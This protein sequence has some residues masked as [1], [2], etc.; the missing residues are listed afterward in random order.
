[1]NKRFVLGG[2]VSLVT[3]MFVTPGLTQQ[4]G[5]EDEIPLEDE[6]PIEEELIETTEN[7]LN[8][9]VITIYRDDGFSGRAKKIYLRDGARIDLKMKCPGL[10]DKISSFKLN[11]PIDTSVTVYQ[12]RSCNGCKTYSGTFW[13]SGIGRERSVDKRTLQYLGVHDNITRIHFKVNGY[14]PNNQFQNPTC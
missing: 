3:L 1:M 9:A 11:A 10:H 5:E 4:G 14:F 8:D 2:L 12:R 13:G 7:M 6:I